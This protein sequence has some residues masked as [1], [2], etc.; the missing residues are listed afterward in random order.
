MTE[1]KQEDKSSAM[2]KLA[3]FIVDKRNL[4]FL[5]L[6]IGILFSLFSRNWIKVENDLKAYL[7]DSSESR[8]GLDVME[9]QFITYGTAQI[10][11]ENVSAKQAESIC[12]EIKDVSGVQSVDYDEAEDYRNVSALYAVTFAFSEKDEKCLRSLEAVKTA[13]SGRDY[14]VSTSLGN[15]AAEI[16][17]QEVNVIM[18]LVAVIVVAVLLLTSQTYAEIPVLLLTFVSAMILNQGSQFLMGKISFVSNSVTSILQLALSLDY[19]VILCNR[20]KEERE[21]MPIREAVITALSKGIP[22]IGSSSLTT[23]GGLIAMLFMQFK[24]GPDMA[25]NLIKAVLFAL[26]A[27]FVFMPGFLMLFGPLMDKTRHRNFVPKIPFVGSFDYKTRYLIPP[28]FLAVMLLGYHFSGECPYAYGYG[29]IETPKLNFVQIAQNKITDNFGANN[30]VALVYPKADYSVEKRMLEELDRYEE[31]DYSMGLSNV[32]AMDGYMLADKL[33]PRQFAELAGLDYELAEAVYAAYAVEQD[34]LGKIIGGLNTYKVPLIDMM[35]FV[36]DKIDAGL[37]TLD[38]TQMDVLKDA[39][40][41]MK[42]AKKQLQGEDYNR[43]LVYLT[44]P[45]GGDETYRF[46]D[47]IREIARGYYPSGNIY[48]VGNSTVE[49]DFKTSFA[50][51]NLII[52]V[53]SILI[54]LVVLLFTFQSAGMPLLLILVIQ[55]SIW[56]NFSVPALTNAP[57]F[58]MSY[59]VVSSIQMGANIDYAIVISSRYQELKTQM[60]HRNAIIET[61]NFAFPTILTSGTILACAGTLIGMMTSEVAIV[62]IG[63]SLGRGTVL[64]IGLVMF[65]LPQILLIGGEIVDKTSFRM[66]KANLP[67]LSSTGHMRVDGL[68]RGEIHGY[69]NG[70][71]HAD[72]NG[73]VDLNLLTGRSTQEGEN[74]NEA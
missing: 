6:A 5:L 69:V 54:V 59:L 25:I 71:I 41:Q 35:L 18:V 60:P 58:F 62:G 45:E 1:S 34:E 20:Y 39:Q 4:F 65:V 38:D 70:I 27:V 13:L 67:R 55:G 15:S 14:Y 33:T 10:M 50:T 66:P 8:Q 42:S 2:T 3:T 61:M 31:V 43:V 64:S 40:V 44:L 21:Q 16:I 17:S 53:V 72:I 28:I 48:V 30:F 73:D 63:Q 23:I 68:V 46:L 7:P 52:T 11:V 47:K 74:G 37:V 56:I 22:E 51:D 19:A 36:C 32:E 29:G 49:Q 24:I 26:L 12:E 9:D 57:L